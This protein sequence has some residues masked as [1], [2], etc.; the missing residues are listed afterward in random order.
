[1]SSLSILLINIIL[2]VLDNAVRQEKEIKNIQIGKGE[3]K[4]FSDDM[5]ICVDNTKQ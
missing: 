2:E 5:I 3:I 1:M 4:L